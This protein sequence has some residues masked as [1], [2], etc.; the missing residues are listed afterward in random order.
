MAKAREAARERPEEIREEPGVEV[1]GFSVTGTLGSGVRGTVYSVSDG[2]RS[3]AAKV[4]R[5]GVSLDEKTL[6]RFAKGSG[7]AFAN[8]IRHPNLIPIEVVGR[9]PD[10]SHYYLMPL[11]RGDS[12]D[13]LLLDLKRGASDC[14]SLSPFSIGPGGETHPQLLRRAAELIA[15]VADGLELAHRDGPGGIVHRRLSPRNLILSPAG[16]LVVTDFG[17]E[18]ATESVLELAYGA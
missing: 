11:L 18:G 15:E 9:L 1:P 2:K 16:R 4:L 6:A 8:R 3:L 10:G 17:G 7:T 5:R 13:R 12:L 14:P